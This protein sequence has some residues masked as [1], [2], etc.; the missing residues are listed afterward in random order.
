MEQK[1]KIVELYPSK[2]TDEEWVIYHN[3]RRK[4]HIEKN[5]ED[6][7]TEDEDAVKTLVANLNHPEAEMHYFSVLDTE[8]NLQV[9]SMMYAIVKDNSP[10]YEGMKEIVSFNI[11]FLKENRTQELENLALQRVYEFAAEKQKSVLI[12]NSDEEEGKR[13]FK[14][15]GAQEALA[16]I[17]NRL[18]LKKLDWNLVKQW[19]KDGIM[20]SPDTRIEFHSIIPNAIIDSFCRV[21][22]EVINQQPFDNLDIGKMIFTPESYR[23]QEQMFESVGRRKLIFLSFEP[24]GKI[25]GLTEMLYN[26]KKETM[27]EQMMTGVGEEYRGRGLGKLLKAQM[28]LMLKNDYPQIKT[29]TTTNAT[30]NEPM[31]SINERLGF[32]VYKEDISAQITTSTL[33][34]YLSKIN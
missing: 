34:E 31:I 2:M 19:T 12:T 9:G 32:E 3:Y 15:I 8:L 28:L 29:I 14:R 17:E 5:P 20:K 7:I 33:G 18:N 21:Y 24:D 6:P 25:S 27:I 13:F 1:V 4:R 16:G 11:E 26:T 23:Q 30:S 10:S 22:T